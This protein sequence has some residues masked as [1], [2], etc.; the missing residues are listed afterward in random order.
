MYV[1]SC[2]TGK[3]VRHLL[4]QNYREDGKV[5]HRTIA[6]ISSCSAEEIAA[7]KLAL[8]HKGN[9]AELGSAS[10]T[11]VFLSQGYSMGAVWTLYEMAKQL[12]ITR[13]LGS[14]RQ[15]KL[16]LW[17]VIAR[18]ID[19]GSRLSAVRLAKAHGA[20]EI[21]GIQEPFNEDDLYENM[22]WLCVSQDR[23]EQ[24]MFQHGHGERKPQLFLYDVTSSYLE[25]DCNAF[26]AFGYNRDGKRGKKQIVIGLLCDE[27]GIPLSIEVFPGNTQDPKTVS[28]QIRKL[29]ERFGG[30]ELTLVGDR[31]MLKTRE[32]QEVQEHGFHYITAI[33]KPQVEALIKQ[34]LI[35]LDL[36]EQDL[37]EVEDKD[38]IRYIL[39]RNPVRA[40]ECA[41]TRRD[42]LDTLEGFIGKKNE[43]L[44]EHPRSRIEVAA[45]HA[46]E[47]RNKLRIEGWVELMI[48]GREIHLRIDEAAKTEASRLDGC[49][50]IKTD[51]AVEKC[52]MQTAHD[53][54]KD[55]THV[56]RAFRTSKT[57]ELQMRPIHVCLAARTRA[58]ALVVMLAYR[59]AQELSRR[60][61]TANMKIQEGIDLL[62]MLCVHDVQTGGQTACALVSEPSAQT[63]ELLSLA[64]VILPASLPRRKI[65]V[66]TRRKLQ[67]RRQRA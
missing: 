15:G 50:V 14:T 48:E 19:Q 28:S 59:I 65:H 52:S 26:A 35:Q 23:I 13:A 34:G 6:N 20:C 30:D 32:L 22:D 24:R 47:L 61:V 64:G 62:S 7:I 41:A 9:L 12:G 21:L 29:A 40:Q 63:R 5:K 38:G 3:Y 42:K 54:Y 66:A 18:V 36:F 2:K 8:K 49:Y 10:I 39:R 58:H 25:G 56:E 33:T 11:E 46:D 37:A 16:A 43:Y 44:K 27:Q 53:R 67:K 55:L 4:R 17:Q 57:V 60:W 51:L 45:R 31:G 1:D